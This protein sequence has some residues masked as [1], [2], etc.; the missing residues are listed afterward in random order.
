MLDCGSGES[1]ILPEREAK[2]KA[3]LMQWQDK[4]A[5]ANQ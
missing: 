4:Q 1:S 5:M 2:T 3:L